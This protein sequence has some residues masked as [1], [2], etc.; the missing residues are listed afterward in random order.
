MVEVSVPTAAEALSI[1]FHTL[2]ADRLSANGTAIFTS[3][4]HKRHESGEH[5]GIPLSFGHRREQR[6]IQP[7]VSDIISAN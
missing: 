7:R 4:L 3:T 1:E 2:A 6:Y 5:E